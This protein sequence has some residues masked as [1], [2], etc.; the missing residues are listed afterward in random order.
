MK[1]YKPTEQRPTDAYVV[2]A[3]HLLWEL[4]AETGNDDYFWK[5]VVALEFALKLS[6]ASYHL[7]FLLVRFYNKIGKGFFYFLV[8]DRALQAR[9]RRCCGCS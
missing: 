1:D 8:V 2:L 3:G 7:R 5:A 6:P 9:C 4:W